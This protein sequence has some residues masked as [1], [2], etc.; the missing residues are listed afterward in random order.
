MN[1]KPITLQELLNLKNELSNEV[2][3]FWGS[4]KIKPEKWIENEFGNE[5]DGFWV[6]AIYQNYA[7]SYNDI[8]NG[9]NISE[10]KSK[11]HILGYS[12]EQDELKF[13]IIKLQNSDSTNL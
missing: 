9:F 10:F 1:W 7:M 5:G 2:L 12:T 6:V 8:E 3:A 4:I 11:G 13:S